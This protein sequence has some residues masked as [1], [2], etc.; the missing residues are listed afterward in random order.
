M[1]NSG[2]I[3]FEKTTFNTNEVWESGSRYTRTRTRTHTRTV[4]S[5]RRKAREVANGSLG[6]AR[7]FFF[8]LRSLLIFIPARVLRAISIL[9]RPSSRQV[10]GALGNDC[11][12]EPPVYT[13]NL[14]L[15]SGDAAVWCAIA[16]AI[17]QHDT[18]S[19]AVTAT[20]TG[21]VPSSRLTMHSPLQWSMQW[22]QPRYRRTWHDRR[23]STGWRI[24]VACSRT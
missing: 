1:F 3:E 23:Q 21:P 9:K 11:W 6:C 7:A 18:Q 10:P 15:V 13:V 22:L 2:W 16:C 19:R 8:S 14:A 17:H 20:A 4:C 12:P 5:E 24:T